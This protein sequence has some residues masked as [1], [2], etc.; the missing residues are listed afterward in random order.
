MWL[1]AFFSIVPA[2]V[3]QL[4]WLLAIGSVAYH[5]FKRAEKRTYV[6]RYGQEQL[7]YQIAPEGSLF[8][9]FLALSNYW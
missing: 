5:F 8:L 4:A 1:T 3:W 2:M 9:V 6:D 7:E